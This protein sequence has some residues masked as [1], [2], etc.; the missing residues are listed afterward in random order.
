MATTTSLVQRNP[1]RPNSVKPKR[2][3]D[4][5]LAPWCAGRQVW[6]G[7]D[8]EVLASTDV[9]LS[10]D[11]SALLPLITLLLKTLARG[12]LPLE[13]LV[14][15]SRSPRVRSAGIPA[16]LA[17][18]SISFVAIGVLSTIAYALLY[19]ILRNGT[20]AQVANLLAL[21]ITAVVNTA[22]NRRLTF[23]VCGSHKAA[24]HQIQ[25]LVVFAIGLGLTSGSLAALHLLAPAAGKTVEL[26]VLVLA[27][28]AAT[29]IRFL[30]MRIWI[31]RPSDT[32]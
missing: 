20:G 22:A 11:L 10:T 9:D 6:L 1:V 4:E 3:P 5:G 23:G 13:T 28:L 12:D 8:A 25:G 32:A 14:T 30:A 27:N 2:P 19:M 29:V 15:D 16:G 26:A 24:T 17:W 18:Q 31:F 7:S 21:L